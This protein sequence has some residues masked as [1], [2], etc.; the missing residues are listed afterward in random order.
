MEIYQIHVRG[1]SA[2][3]DSEFTMSSKD[4]FKREPTQEE[5]DKFIK[6]CCDPEYFFY[7][8]KNKPYEIKIFHLNLIED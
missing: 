2:V 5:I 4:V 7:M 1:E 3:L 6:A 8:D